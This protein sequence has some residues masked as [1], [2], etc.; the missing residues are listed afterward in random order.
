MTLILGIDAAWSRK[1]PS[2][3]ALVATNPNRPRLIRAAPSYEHFVRD[4][5]PEDWGAPSDSCANLCQLLVE[6][7]KIA[8]EP[9]SVITVDMPVAQSPVRKRRCCD[10]M[11]SKEFGGRWCSTHSPTKERPGTISDTFFEDA[12]KAGFRLKTIGSDG[13]Q[14]ALLEVYPHVALLELCEAERR[15]PYKLSKRAKNFSTLR[16]SGRLDAVMDEWSKIIVCLESR[17]DTDLNLD[18]GI[19]GLRVWK[20]WEDVIDAIVCCWVG[21]EWLAGRAKAYGDDDAAIW[22]PR[23]QVKQAV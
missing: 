18:R 17:I 4:T 14:P 15:L 6:A 3:V 1:N 12:V 20:A 23:P 11:I 21:V 13:A 10:I 5:P 16:P 9:V 8:G 7:Q 19:K 2:G 22:V